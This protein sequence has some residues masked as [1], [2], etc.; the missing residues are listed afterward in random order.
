MSTPARSRPLGMV[1][2]CVLA[3]LTVGVPPV[4][5]DLGRNGGIVILPNATH[6][7]E[8]GKVVRATCT[9]QAN[10]NVALQFTTG[11]GDV[12]VFADDGDGA[13]PFGTVGGSVLTVRA[14]DLEEL[15]SAG[16]S[17]FV[18]RV[19]NEECLGYDLRF[20]LRP[21]GDVLVEVR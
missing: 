11:L 7:S 19:V 1:L 13:I 14:A 9:F 2:L 5:G 15:R 6:H 18:L 17:E 21:A 4:K 16:V 20:V 3:V 8:W 12:V 10:E